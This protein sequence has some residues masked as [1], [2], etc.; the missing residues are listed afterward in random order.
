[1][2]NYNEKSLK[3]ILDDMS[4]NLSVNPRGTDKGDYKSYIDKFYEKE[5]IKLT[6]KDHIRILEIGVRHGASVA[7]WSEYFKSVE[8]T[9]IDSFVDSS[10][11]RDLPVNERWL[12]RDNFTLISEDAYLS[13]TAK[14]LAGKF[15][16]I[17]DDGPHTLASQ[18]DAVDLYLNKLSKSGVMVIEDIQKYGGLVLLPFIGRV[19]VSF[20]LDVH[21][22][23]LHKPGS[24]NMLVTIRRSNLLLSLINRAY[25]LFKIIM[26][27]GFEPMYRIVCKLRRLPFLSG[28]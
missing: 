7:L 10:I 20:R 16:V 13:D 8:V 9:G 21:D 2:K 15:D 28:R 12:S 17:I 23:R 1:M 5:F 24:D 19:P 22:Y 4:L 26:Y 11:N 18:L 6:L 3:K 14:Q 27:L 25:L